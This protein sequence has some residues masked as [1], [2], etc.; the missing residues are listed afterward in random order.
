VRTGS[1]KL[2]AGTGSWPLDLEHDLITRA[3]NGDEAAFT[4]L[5]EH[6]QDRVYRTAWMYVQDAALASELAHEAFVRL[7]GSLPAFRFGAALSTWLHRVVLN[8]C[9]D[10]AR[11]RD[12]E[13]RLVP[14]SEV[15]GLPSSEPGPELIAIREASDER[16]REA[17]RRLPPELR[18]QVALRFGGGLTY[19]EISV[20]LGVPLGTVCTRMQR[21]MAFLAADL[22]PTDQEE[23]Q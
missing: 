17:V 11:R 3:A 20:A 21:A 12:R 4:R 16:V 7:H 2:G 22:R 10:A 14:L 6:H 5:V 1:W 8:L 19:A 23:P 15:D 13:R 9:H 18:E